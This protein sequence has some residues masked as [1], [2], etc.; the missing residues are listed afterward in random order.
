MRVDGARSKKAIMLV[1]APLICLC[2]T[3]LLPAEG[4]EPSSAETLGS[5][6][7]AGSASILG[8]ESSS[9]LLA[10]EAR[11]YEGL[12]AWFSEELFWLDVQR[13]YA[14]EDLGVYGM[15]CDMPLAEAAE[16]ITSQ[17]EERGWLDLGSSTDGYLS[18][19]KP[20]E[21]FPS[22]AVSLV[23]VSGQTTVVVQLV[24]WS[25]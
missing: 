21:G 19:G 20:G 14:S 24:G 4:T 5:V 9:D 23:E 2:L 13:G 25:I 18:F 12:P 11:A 7:R 17:M 16:D 15:V 22:A 10:C 3:G 1:L 6:V 8:D